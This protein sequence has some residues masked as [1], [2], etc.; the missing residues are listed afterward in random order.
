[1]I[2]RHN[3]IDRQYHAMLVG[4]VVSAAS[5]SSRPL[6]SGAHEAAAISRSQLFRN[7][8]SFPSPIVASP[9]IEYASLSAR[10][11]R[12]R[13]L[14]CPLNERQ[15]IHEMFLHEYTIAGIIHQTQYRSRC[16]RR[17]NI[18]TISSPITSR[19]CASSRMRHMEC[20]SSTAWGIG[21]M[22]II[23]TAITI[24]VVIIVIIFTSRHH[25]HITRMCFIQC[26]LR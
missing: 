18:S 14:R 6:L 11:T 20:L 2:V 22:A 21:I 17:H 7:S 19:Y 10:Y 12:C 1:M 24:I 3:Y 13:C 9:L 8:E 25:P 16:S 4:V 15:I 23:T 5:S 26:T